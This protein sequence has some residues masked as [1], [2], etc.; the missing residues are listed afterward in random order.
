MERATKSD[1]LWSCRRT[2][3]IVG[4]PTPFWP[5][6]AA[7]RTGLRPRSCSSLTGKQRPKNNPSLSIRL[8]GNGEHGPSGVL[9]RRG[10]PL[11][12]PRTVPVPTADNGLQAVVLAECQANGDRG[13][14]PPASG[15]LWRTAVETVPTHVT[16]SLRLRATW[17]AAH[18]PRLAPPQLAQ[19]AAYIVQ[20]ETARTPLAF[21]AVL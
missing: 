2:P 18:R 5:P 11:G 6:S 4:S 1:R 9:R 10:S 14:T 7:R 8:D 19:W 20:R 3:S 13:R 21:D 12:Q 15:N 17:Q 16:D